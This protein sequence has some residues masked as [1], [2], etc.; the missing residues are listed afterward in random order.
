M[1]QG[2]LAD[3]N[4]VM[5]GGKVLEKQAQFAK[6]IGGHEM[7][8]IDD[9][10]QHFSGLVDFVGLFDQASFAAVIMTLEIDLEGAA[11]DAQGVVIGMKSSVEQGSDHAF[12]IMI[13][14]GVFDEA[15]A[16]ARFAQDQAEA[17]LL[18]VDAEDVE[19]F[20]LVVEQRAG[21]RIERVALQSEVRT[22]HR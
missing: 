20:L 15:F 4:E 12:W 8:I 10:H 9:G 13:E 7:G 18:G 14:Q 17:A 16:C 3:E 19:D 21:L 11:E 5:G 2:Q 6:T 1:K 22:N